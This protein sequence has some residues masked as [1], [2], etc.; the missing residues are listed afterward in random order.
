MAGLQQRLEVFSDWLIAFAE[1]LKSRA[2]EYRVNV[3]D[4]FNNSLCALV[5]LDKELYEVEG[6]VCFALE[7]LRAEVLRRTDEMLRCLDSSEDSISLDITESES[8]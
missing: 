1:D 3:R 2:V 5:D 7:D 8:E 6:N 4:T